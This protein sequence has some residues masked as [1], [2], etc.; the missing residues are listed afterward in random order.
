MQRAHKMRGSS[1][2][3]LGS[4][5][6][7]RPCQR[8]RPKCLAPLAAFVF[9]ALALLPAAAQEK[10]APSAPRAGW[11]DGNQIRREFSEKL[12]NGIYPTGNPWSEQ[13]FADGT[14]D[15]R[16]GEKRWR[17]TWWTESRAFCFRYP[18]P[19]VGGCFAVVRL[20]SNCYELYEISGAMPDE[21]PPELAG[22]WNG[23]MWVADRPATCDEKPTS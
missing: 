5:T 20:G 21:R 12:L 14:T 8:V 2:Q 10:Q 9:I 7:S 16:E 19:G 23:R 13:L 11:L 17:G 3:T 4:D 15:Y 22:S 18:P 6:G 1:G